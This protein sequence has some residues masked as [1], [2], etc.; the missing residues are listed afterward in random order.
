M[1]VPIVSHCIAPSVS[2][3]LLAPLLRAERPLDAPAAKAS[4]TPPA[5]APDSAQ[6]TAL[7]HL[8]SQTLLGERRPTTDN[9]SLWL[10]YLGVPPNSD[11]TAQKQWLI[12]NEATVRN[13]LGKAV[14]DTLPP[15][16]A[17]DALQMGLEEDLQKYVRKL[18]ASGSPSVAAHLSSAALRLT[19]YTLRSDETPAQT[20]SSAQWYGAVGPTASAPTSLAAPKGISINA[21]LVIENADLRREVTALIESLSIMRQLAEKH[22]NQPAGIGSE[23]QSLTQRYQSI[24]AAIKQLETESDPH[25]KNLLVR[26][27]DAWQFNSSY[28]DFPIWGWRTG[29]NTGLE[30]FHRRTSPG[31]GRYGTSLE[32]IA[33]GWKTFSEGIQSLPAVQV[34]DV[35]AIHHDKMMPSIEKAKKQRDEA[36][37]ALTLKPS[38]S[39]T[40]ASLHQKQAD[41]NVLFQALSSAL[42][43]EQRIVE[44]FIKNITR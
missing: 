27:K 23:W 9:T 29:G 44:M 28:P 13:A 21:A 2:P 16:R 40:L 20:A 38:D 30:H 34:D 35:F 22:R 7:L 33:K 17:R 18:A 12:G 15:S 37:S 25:V 14:R 36:A 6:H 39:L 11:A 32:N 19:E 26:V 1:P 31:M 4:D 10:S 5:A 42:R 43:N 41:Y 8:L 24:N 3:S